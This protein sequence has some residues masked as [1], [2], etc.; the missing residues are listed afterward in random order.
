MVVNVA[1]MYA[2]YWPSVL[3]ITLAYLLWL[4]HLMKL[5]YDRTCDASAYAQIRQR[6]S[7]ARRTAG[8][9]EADS[10]TT[11]IAGKVSEPLGVGRGREGQKE[12]RLRGS[13][14]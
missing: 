9:G 12:Y 13:W 8:T 2:I 14:T 6:G 5:S 7:Q 3:I 10:S 4:I 11:A 1:L